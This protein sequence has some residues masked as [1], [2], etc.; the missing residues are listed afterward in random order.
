M[1]LFGA[2]TAAMGC[3]TN[4]SVLL[5]QEKLFI[6]KFCQSNPQI[7]DKCDIYSLHSLLQKKNNKR[8]NKPDLWPQ[9]LNDINFLMRHKKIKQNSLQDIKLH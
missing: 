3:N 8:K 9:I 6:Q 5:V 4:P 7:E 2:V 1:Q